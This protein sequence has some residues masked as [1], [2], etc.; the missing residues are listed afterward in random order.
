MAQPVFIL[1]A[2][3][4]KLLHWLGSHPD[5]RTFEGYEDAPHPNPSNKRKKTVLIEEGEEPPLESNVQEEFL[6][7][8][9][10]NLADQKQKELAPPSKSP[11]QKIFLGKLYSKLCWNRDEFLKKLDEIKKSNPLQE[12]FVE[13]VLWEWNEYFRNVFNR[14]KSKGFRKS[15]Q[16]SM[17]L[18]TFLHCFWL[19]TVPKDATI[20]R[21]FF[22]F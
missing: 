6:R 15:V 22:C 3:D 19:P 20:K 12:H 7:T 17:D 4:E 21:Y 10:K 8:V 5:N 11:S 14:K 2:E 9:A 18:V 16:K 13:S 1:S